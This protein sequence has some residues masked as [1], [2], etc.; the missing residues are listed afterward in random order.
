MANIDPAQVSG[1]RQ[2][3]DT[4][5]MGTMIRDALKEWSDKDKQ[6]HSEV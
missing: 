4:G 2:R 5:G 3:L 1:V 6:Q